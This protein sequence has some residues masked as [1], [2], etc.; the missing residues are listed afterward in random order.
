MTAIRKPVIYLHHTRDADGDVIFFFIDPRDPGAAVRQSSPVRSLRRASSAVL[1]L[2]G[3]G[4]LATYILATA[5]SE[6]QVQLPR[7]TANHLAA[8]LAGPLS[9]RGGGGRQTGPCL[10]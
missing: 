10:V 3:H 5:N 7:D 1:D 6:Y 8:E 4:S 9:G 2:H